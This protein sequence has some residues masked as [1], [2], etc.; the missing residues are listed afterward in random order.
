VSVQGRRP[1]GRWTVLP[2]HPHRLHLAAALGLSPVTAQILAHRGYHNPEAAERFLRAP[3][4]SLPDPLRVPD[5]AR[6]AE[7]V[8]NAGRSGQRIAV[9]GDFDTDGVC[10][11]AVLVRGL[12]ELGVEATPYVPHRLREGYG[13]SPEAVRS[14]AEAGVRC[15]VTVDC[16]V[17]A[18]AALEL[19]RDLGLQTVVV[20]HHAPPPTLPPADVVVDP[21]LQERPYPFRDYCAT[22]LAWLVVRAVRG[23]AGTSPTEDLVEL[24]A[25]ATVSDVVPLVGDN[26]VLVRAGLE[27]IPASPLPGLRELVRVAGVAGPVR[28]DDVAW[29]LAPRLNA[30]G[31]VDSAGW[32]LRLLLTDDPE[33]AR[34]LAARLEV[35]NAHRQRLHE[36]ALGAAVAQVEELGL[37][38]RPAVV[39]WGEGWHPGVVG[40]VAGRL[41]EA[42]GRPAVALSLEGPRARGSARGVPGL[43]LVD[44]LRECAHLLDRFGG[45]AQ[46]AGLELA[47]DRLEAFRERFERVVADRLGAEPPVPTLT[48]EAEASLQDLD[49]RLVE[50]LERLEPYGAGNPRP[51]VLVT[52]VEPL[53]VGAWGT[54][55]HL[56]M[57][58]WDGARSVE[59]VGFGLGEWGELVAFARP[60]LQLA[61]FPER[62]RWRGGLRFVVE[63]LSA[64]EVDAERVL[65]DTEALLQRLR[66][67][68]EDYLADLYRGVELRPALYTKVVGVTFEGRQD[69]VAR[70]RPGEPLRLVREPANPQ[71][72]HAVRVV[73]EDG[74]SVGYLSAAV[75]GR[76]APQMDRGARYRATVADVTGGG[77]R[78]LGVNVRLE[79]EEDAQRSHRRWVRASLASASE[80]DRLVP[81]VT[82]G[83]GL[84]EGPQR[85][86]HCVREG[87]RAFVASAPGQAWSDLVA[88]A[89]A[90]GGLAGR[91]VWVFPTCELAEARWEAW[92]HALERAGLEPV[93]L[94]GLVPVRELA[95]SEEVVRQ[96][97]GDVVFTTRAYV[98]W[99]PE[100]LDRSA[101]VAAEGWWSAELPGF[102]AHHPGPALWVVW[103]PSA[104]PPEGWEAFGDLVP[105]TGVRLVDHRGTE[106]RQ[107]LVASW[108]REHGR[109]VLFA[110]G[111]RSAV[112]WAEQLSSHGPVA[113]D[114]PGLPHR[115][116][117]TLVD[118]LSQGR[119]KCIVCGAEAPAALRGVDRA[120]WLAPCG[121]ERFLQQA[122]CV[123]D[124]SSRVTLGLAFGADDVEE[125]GKAVWSQHPPKS[126]LAAVY[127]LL[128]EVSEVRWPEAGLAAAVAEAT[129][130]DPTVLVPACVRTF[131]QA[132]LVCKE[133]AGRGWRLNVLQVEGRRD[134]ARVPRFQ[135]GEASR[136][137][138]EAGA[139][140]LARTPAVGVLER[141]ASPS[142]AARAGTGTG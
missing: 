98:E 12:R 115:V 95:E 68:A 18:F 15:L 33:E 103:D 16:G 17:G 47:G 58:V 126:V 102:L 60:C 124:G 117:Q 5:L 140:F 61:G 129:G 123:L 21:K 141:V 138:F 31:R 79:L 22:A 93:R 1:A 34:D 132:G 109:L 7:V 42:Y 2:P 35:H 59:A 114:H 14:L 65:S 52:G 70:L 6:A 72:P 62:D 107:A 84:A 40:L 78:Y 4:D 105:R 10:A 130:L 43:D 121:P 111:A 53:E 32:S 66:E 57:R 11:V 137:A 83:R 20:D 94:H 9:H 136:A 133:R 46:A 118:L 91:A 112:R 30:A 142:V 50:E 25:L 89:V 74:T 67:R 8:W 108:L 122:A 45:H 135:E 71:D 101:V 88:A 80:A 127:R 73:R 56:W 36:E 106:G 99:R 82:G 75:A 125:A 113:Y 77:D 55:E 48:V 110:P 41:R 120:V 37:G 51:L 131:E 139:A 92:R 19:A 116:R 23:L 13:V 104:R 54:G 81:L 69:V 119:L 134:L 85:A 38:R 76:L 49:D 24:V 26:R 96:G 97:G 128:R 28:A 29:R 100:V 87:G 39:V 44:A 86:L 27:R 3:L 90:A 63:D 64:P